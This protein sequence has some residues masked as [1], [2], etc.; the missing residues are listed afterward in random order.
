MDARERHM[1]LTD[2]SAMTERA[3]P[4]DTV[5]E[6]PPSASP[7]VEPRTG[8]EPS[9]TT[10]Q[11]PELIAS[12]PKWSLEEEQSPITGWVGFAI[13]MVFCIL[14]AAI[15]NPP[16]W[17]AGIWPWRCSIMLA[18]IS[19]GMAAVELFVF[20]THRRNF[21]FAAPRELDVEAWKRVGSRWAALSFCIGVATFLY[22]TLKFYSFWRFPYHGGE[23]PEIADKLCLDFTI[24]RTFYI[25]AV[26]VVVVFSIPYFWMVER[27]A[28]ADGPADEFLALS[29]WLSKFPRCLW[30]ADYA[31]KMENAHVA[32][33]FRGLLVKFVYVPLMLIWTFSCFTGWENDAHATID[34]MQTA[35]WRTATDVALNFLSFNRSML[36]LMI[37]TDL[38][39]AVVGYMVSMRLLDNHVVSAEPTLLG[40]MAALMCYPPFRTGVTIVLLQ[41]DSQD[42]WKQ[43]LF[44]D[45]PEL[46][47]TLAIIS[48]S[49]WAVYVWAT[50]SFG[51]RFSNLTNRGILCSGPY[52]YI[53]HPAYVCKNASWWLAAIPAIMRFSGTDPSAIFIILCRSVTS[54]VIYGLRAWTEERHLMREPHYREYCKKVPWR[55]FPGIW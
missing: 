48:L 31:Q 32:N 22:V 17:L 35:S 8:Q 12:R 20:K 44:K 33:L 23:G 1:R 27:Y 5:R 7:A 25:F 2:G 6:L 41:T 47:I 29:S 43:E 40:W 45:Y 10:P 46:S 55:I 21:D 37:L 18:A 3:E 4:M 52:A 28:R 16:E 34:A 38:T 24:F 9:A 42:V 51:L 14:A 36:T 13:L 54:N 19:L 50:I 30:A 53:R 39:I 26:P 11:E 15:R 49:L